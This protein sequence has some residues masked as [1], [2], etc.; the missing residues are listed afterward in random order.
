MGGG[1]QVPV[2]LCSWG[3]WDVSSSSRQIS[4]SSLQ[5]LAGQENTERLGYTGTKSKSG[6][7]TQGSAQEKPT[8]ISGDFTVFPNRRC[9][10]IVFLEQGHSLQPSLDGVIKTTSSRGN[11]DP[12]ISTPLCLDA[13]P[14]RLACVDVLS[15]ADQAPA[16]SCDMRMDAFQISAANV[17]PL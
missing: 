8:Y 9:D 6:C 15:R 11:P 12:T 14:H 17:G 13:T 10:A 3:I 4:S 5:I 2:C 7:S 1:L 16:D